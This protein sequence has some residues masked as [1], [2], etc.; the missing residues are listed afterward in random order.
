V[1]G[2]PALSSLS[3]I[4]ALSRAAGRLDVIAV[5]GTGELLVASR[6]AV[7]Q[8]F[9]APATA[10][11]APLAGGV[12]LRLARVESCVALAD[13]SVVVV[14]IG[15]EGGTWLTRFEPGTSTWSQLEPV[16]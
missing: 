8:P 11:G 9:T 16:A 14:A 1:G 7:G 4:A 13:G 5:A 12:P 2:G 10:G 6:P 15:R 3:R